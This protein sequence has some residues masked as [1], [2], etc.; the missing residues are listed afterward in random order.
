MEYR[1][2]SSDPDPLDT[3]ILVLQDRHRSHLVD[4]GQ[5]ASVLTCRHIYLGFMREWEMD[6]HLRP[7]IIQSGFYGVYR[8]GHITLDWGLITSLVERWR[9]ETHTFHLPVGEMTITLQD[10][11]HPP[12]DLDDVTLKQYAQAFIL[13]LIVMVLGE[14]PPRSTRFWSTTSPPA[15]QHLEHDAVDDL[16]AEHLEF[17][18]ALHGKLSCPSSDDI[19][20]RPG[21]L[22]DDVTSYLI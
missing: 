6:P 12:V 10:F 18:E 5:L 16:P 1:G 4:F 13:G 22:E 3:S 8:I 15:A 2:H 9:P 7:Y 17:Y 11:S 20:S 14:T 19:S 21:D